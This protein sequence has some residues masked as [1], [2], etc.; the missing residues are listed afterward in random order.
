VD[1]AAGLEPSGTLA[2]K[3]EDAASCETLCTL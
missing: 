1:R 3:S 2:V